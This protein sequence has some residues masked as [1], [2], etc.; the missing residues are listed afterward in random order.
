MLAVNGK[1]NKIF[2][3]FP[4]R[5]PCDRDFGF[6]KGVLLQIN[7]VYTPEDFCTLIEL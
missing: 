6:I 7:T 1:F 5:E 4:V 3:H 2:Q